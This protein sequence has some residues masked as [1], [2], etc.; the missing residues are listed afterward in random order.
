MLLNEVGSEDLHVVAVNLDLEISAFELFERAAGLPLYG[1][2]LVIAGHGYAIF[3]G[4]T[5]Y[6]AAIARVL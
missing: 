5:F 4:E 3:G 6:R 2:S 1:S